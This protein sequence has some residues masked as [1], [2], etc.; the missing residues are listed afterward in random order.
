MTA[1]PF[2]T[3]VLEALLTLQGEPTSGLPRPVATVRSKRSLT[4]T[5]VPEGVA[6]RSFESGPSPAALTALTL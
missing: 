5:P 4:M 3:F 6:E 1:S 2:C